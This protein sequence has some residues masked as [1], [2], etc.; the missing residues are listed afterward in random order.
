MAKHFDLDITG[1]AFSF[2]R[3]TTEIAAEAATDG[4]YVV[5]TSLPAEALDDAATVRSYKSLAW[6]SV[7]SAAASWRRR[8]AQRLRSASRRRA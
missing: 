6:W 7:P 5:R 1:A 3:K 2:A 4:V 8:S